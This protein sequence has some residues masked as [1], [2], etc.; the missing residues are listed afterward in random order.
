MTDDDNNEPG[1]QT[2]EGEPPE[3]S[4]PHCEDIEKLK[5]AVEALATGAVEGGEDDADAGLEALGELFGVG[6]DA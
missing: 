6:E 5:A 4:C 1:E 2:T 3:H